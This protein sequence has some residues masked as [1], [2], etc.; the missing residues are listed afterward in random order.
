MKTLVL[1]AVL[2]VEAANVY[3]IRPVIYRRPDPTA[4]MVRVDGRLRGASDVLTTLTVLAPEDVGLTASAQPSLF[5]YQSHGSETRIEL[6]VLRDTAAKPAF[7]A[8]VETPAAGGV[9]RFRLADKGFKLEPGTSYRWSVSIVTDPENRSKD[10]VA[11]GMI[12]YAPLSDKAQQRLAANQNDKAYVYADEGYWYD[13]L[14]ALS[15]EI[16]QK[17]SERELRKVRGM[18]FLQAGLKEASDHDLKS[19]GKGTGAEAP[20]KP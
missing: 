13:A 5:W 11:S 18:L 1:M 6:T 10:V 19:I 3:A 20:Q 2:A 16:D 7:E 15:D 9:R 8:V 14:E 4:P 12:R 17:P